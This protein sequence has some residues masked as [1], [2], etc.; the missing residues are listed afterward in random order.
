MAIRNGFKQFLDSKFYTDDVYKAVG[1][2]TDPTPG[3]VY[4]NS[5]FITEDNRPQGKYYLLLDG[6]NDQWGDDLEK[7]ELYLYVWICDEARN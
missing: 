4:L 6:H 5:Y 7:L 1:C 2:N 3:F